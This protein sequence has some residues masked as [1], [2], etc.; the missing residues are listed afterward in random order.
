MD[1]G[2]T[3]GSHDILEISKH[4]EEKTM[5]DDLEEIARELKSLLE[6]LVRSLSGARFNTFRSLASGYDRYAA[7]NPHLTTKSTE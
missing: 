4:R 7:M 1:P 5:I 3:N 6:R 2:D